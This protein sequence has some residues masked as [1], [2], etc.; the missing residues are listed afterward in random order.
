MLRNQPWDVVDVAVGD[1]E[2]PCWRSVIGD[3]KPVI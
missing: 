3:V 2:R 1:I